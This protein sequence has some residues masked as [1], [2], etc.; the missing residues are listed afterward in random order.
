MKKNVGTADTVIRLI[1]VI[2][3][4]LLYLTDVISGT[5]AVIFGVVALIL[6]ITG[7]V[8]VCPAYWLFKIN[9]SKKK[10]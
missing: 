9:T 2:L 1:L 7:L 3:I 10:A 6:L 4:G 8:G 5:A